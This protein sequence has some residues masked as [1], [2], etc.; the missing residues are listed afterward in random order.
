MAKQIARKILESLCGL[1]IGAGVA[2]GCAQESAIPVTPPPL[3]PACEAPAGDIAAPAQL[4]HVTAALRR[5]RLRV[6]AIGSSSTAGVG[7]SSEAKTYPAQLEAILEG[8]LSN[9][10]VVIVN[11]GVSGEVASVTAE[12]IKSEIAVE[13]PDLLL[14]Q[15]GTNDALVRIAPEEFEATVRSTI[16][17]LK[18]NEI[19]TVLVGLQ[20]SSRF[21]RDSEYFAIRDALQR[22]AAAE[23][24]AYVRRYD[25]M[26][27]IAQN[28]AN[29]Q[30]MARD[31]FHLNDLGYQCM[32][33]HIARAVIVGLFA[34]RR[35]P[36]N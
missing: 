26:R 28:R 34:K 13:K 12:R 20:Y 33:E 25:A 9:V 29:L 2:A 18:D 17:W 5:G 16:R 11:R 3:S 30:L 15:L 4:P 24:I 19:D 10:D 21:S 31:N 14:W 8:A 6:L 32:A 35:P 23:N 22:V 1:V 7:A 27:F 36:T